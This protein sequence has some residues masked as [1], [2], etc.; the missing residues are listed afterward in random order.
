MA[1]KIKIKSSPC[2]LMQEKMMPWEQEQAIRKTRYAKAAAAAKASGET[3]E[4][5]KG[6]IERLKGFKETE[7]GKTVKSLGILFDKLPIAGNVSQAVKAAYHFSEG[8]WLNFLAQG[9]KAVPNPVGAQIG[10][11]PEHLG[12]F[13]AEIAAGVKESGEITKKWYQ[14]LDAADK[15][16][17]GILDTV[18][19]DLEMFGKAWA[20][21]EATITE[22][23]QAKI[24]Y[25]K[26][27]KE[28]PE[29]TSQVKEMGGWKALIPGLSE[30]LEEELDWRL[31][32]EEEET[33]I[34]KA[35]AEREK[36]AKGAEE[37]TGPMAAARDLIKRAFSW[38]PSGKV[39]SAL[40]AAG[41]ES[42]V[43]AG[44]VKVVKAA[45]K[46]LPTFTKA[47]TNLETNVGKARKAYAD[48][49]RK[50]GKK[51][52]IESYS[53]EQESQATQFFKKNSDAARMCKVLGG[54][55][56]IEVKTQ[57]SPDSVDWGEI[58]ESRSLTS[59]FEKRNNL[60]YER[61]KR[62]YTY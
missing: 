38:T 60:I 42:E 8:D 17:G 52:G 9:I 62:E 26:V 24:D 50:V 35:E 37:I 40:A 34:G 41:I 31:L 12:Q 59:V 4:K 20:A 15:D 58:R 51:L 32:F 29:I 46:H 27:E 45:R 2:S 57:V 21:A 11:N 30:G 55:E 13:V 14:M 19:D 22:K 44:F 18:F 36:L 5:E 33:Y 23:D 47:F 3:P 48:L 43:D 53:Q 39:K 10:V 7:T 49:V 54:C 16:D 61:L 6:D 56:D 25:K 28:N 1:I